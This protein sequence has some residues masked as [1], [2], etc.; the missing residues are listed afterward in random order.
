MATRLTNRAERLAAIEHILLQ[1][2]AGLRAVEIAEACGVDRRTIYRDLSLLDEGGVPI[3]Q[4]DGRFYLDRERYLATVRLS[5]DELV[6]LVMAAALA[7]R[8]PNSHLATALHKLTKTLPHPIADYARILA[9]RSA[10]GDAAASHEQRLEIIVRAWADR[11]KLRVWYRNR[12]GQRLRVG[13]LSTYVVK[14]KLNGVLYIIGLDS[15]SGEV[16]GFNLER[17]ARVERLDST[18]NIPAQ[19]DWVSQRRPDTSNVAR[20]MKQPER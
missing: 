18:Y 13:D 9:K 14:P 2:V 17:I 3:R 12:D 19:S 7:S 8:R 20:R 15:I 1:N 6:A 11:H 4:Q 5:L 16:R 10:N